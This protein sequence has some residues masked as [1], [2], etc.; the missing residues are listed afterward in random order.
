MVVGKFAPMQCWFI[1]VRGVVADVEGKPV[2]EAALVGS[3]GG[4]RSVGLQAGVLVVA[5]V[6]GAEYS[7][8]HCKAVYR[9]GIFRVV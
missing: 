8:G 2:V 5:P 7:P 3:A 1:V 6:V 4:E 9:D